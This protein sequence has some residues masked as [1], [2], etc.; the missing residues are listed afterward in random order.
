MMTYDD[1]SK[2][3]WIERTPTLKYTLHD[4][5]PMIKVTLFRSSSI[6]LWLQTYKSI[7]GLA[8]RNIAEQSSEDGPLVTCLLNVASGS[9]ID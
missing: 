7:I 4:M 1:I 2:L 3:T 9:S 5:M 6:S 8:K